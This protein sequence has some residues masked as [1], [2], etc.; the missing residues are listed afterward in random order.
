MFFFEG[1]QK[2]W[3]AMAA[4]VAPM[5]PALDLLLTLSTS[6]SNIILSLS[7]GSNQPLKCLM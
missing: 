6:P 3:A 1:G 4:P 2:R 5:A 7:V